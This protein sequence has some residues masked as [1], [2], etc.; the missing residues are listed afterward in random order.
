MT[1][2]E[3]T[4]RQTALYNYLRGMPDPV[5]ALS[6]NDFRFSY[7]FPWK[8]TIKPDTKNYRGDELVSELLY[9]EPFDFPIRRSGLLPSVEGMTNIYD[10]LNCQVSSADIGYFGYRWNETYLNY[11]GELHGAPAGFAFDKAYLQAG[12]AYTLRVQGT[13]EEGRELV[14]L[15]KPD[16]LGRQM[17]MKFADGKYVMPY[18]QEMD[19]E[20]IF[21]LY[22]NQ[23]EDVRIYQD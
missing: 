8:W 15:M 14:Y 18:S 5:D 7:L 23:D 19:R 4:I 17:C 13:D 11:E 1:S 9:Y 6:V 16:N 12:Y 10:S 3:S 21:I 2:L 20:R 22:V